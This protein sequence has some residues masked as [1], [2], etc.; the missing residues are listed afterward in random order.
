MKNLA[1][2]IQHMS[3]KWAKGSTKQSTPNTFGQRSERTDQTKKYILAIWVNDHSHC[4]TCYQ[5]HWYFTLPSNSSYNTIWQQT[6]YFPIYLLFSSYWVPDLFSLF[7]LYSFFKN[8]ECIIWWL[9]NNPSKVCNSI[10]STDFFP[11]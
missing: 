2:S 3:N 1:N 11:L 8:S 5:T 6:L 4:L 9:R 7:F 10:L